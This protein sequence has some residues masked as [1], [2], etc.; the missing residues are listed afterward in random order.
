MP[1]GSRGELA[2]LIAALD[3]G[4][5]ERFLTAATDDGLWPELVAIVDEMPEPSLARVADRVQE[6]PAEHR[7]GL[8]LEARARGT[9]R[10]WTF[11]KRSGEAPM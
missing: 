3:D 8:E 6:L 11:T 1:E 5:L 2:A 4:A 7:R 9:E 10:L